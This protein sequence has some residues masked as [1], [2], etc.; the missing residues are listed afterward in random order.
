MGNGI[1]V[2]DIDIKDLRERDAVRYE[3]EVYRG[4]VHSGSGADVVL[5]I[6]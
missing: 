4:R 6:Y 3:N 2:G 1:Y 5:C